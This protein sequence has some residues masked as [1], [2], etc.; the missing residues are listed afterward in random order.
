MSLG[1][2]FSRRECRNG[3]TWLRLVLAIG[4]FTFHSVTISYGSANAISAA[5]MA[6]A[7]LILPMFFALS[8][9]LVARSLCHCAS[10]TQFAVF[11]TARLA[12]ALV[13]VVLVSM[14][15]IGPSATKERVGDYFLDKQF[16]A[17][18]GNIAAQP[19][20]GLPGVFLNN[21]R[22]GVVNGSL[23]TIPVELVLCAVGAGVTSR[24]DAL[25]QGV[26]Y[27]RVFA[28]G[29]AVGWVLCWEHMG[30]A[31]AHWGT[32]SAVHRGRGDICCI[33]LDTL[34]RAVGGR[35]FYDSNSRINQPIFRAGC[36]IAA[37][38]CNRLAR[39]ASA[40]SA[41]G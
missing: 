7:R 40:S 8:G 41:S 39:H 9:F 25:A 30:R 16:I 13:A 37:G 34:Q 31:T 15:V 1:E 32:D 17:Y 36:R 22:P 27:L 19:H 18:L 21:P 28:S 12:P 26:R 14:L 4:I 33:R 6:V 2:L 35:S 3:F 11:R 38:L 23:W 20:Y 24:P 29:D 5:P 10:L